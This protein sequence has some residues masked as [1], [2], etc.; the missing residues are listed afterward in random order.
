MSALKNNDRTT[1]MDFIDK[2]INNEESPPKLNIGS[3]QSEFKI[4]EYEG[5]QSSLKQQQRPGLEGGGGDDFDLSRL[6]Q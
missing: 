4:P 1:T 2:I 5:I 3:Q 6:M